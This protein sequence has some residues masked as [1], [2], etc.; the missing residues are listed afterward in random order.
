MQT[1]IGFRSGATY[2][3][4]INNFFS[5]N[6]EMDAPQPQYASPDDPSTTPVAA[7]EFEHLL[8]EL[9]RVWEPSDALRT[10]AERYS[11]IVA[12]P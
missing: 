9:E 5:E 7:H 12:T 4:L 2:Y 8:A 10:A 11:A 3:A 1:C 6:S